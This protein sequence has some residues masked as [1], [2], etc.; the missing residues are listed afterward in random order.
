MSFPASFLLVLTLMTATGAA[1][2]A[3]VRTAKEDAA[4]MAQLR[5]AAGRA[6]SIGPAVLTLAAR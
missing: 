5:A 2:V 4:Q 6:S 3:E 1:A